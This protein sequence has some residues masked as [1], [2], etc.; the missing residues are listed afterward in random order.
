LNGVGAEV[1]RESERKRDAILADM[2]RA[3]AK[4]SNA[5]LGNSVIEFD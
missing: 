4:A 1:A 5:W 3:G 2:S